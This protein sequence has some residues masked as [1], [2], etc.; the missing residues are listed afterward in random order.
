MEVLTRA[1][2]IVEEKDL[3][4]NGIVLPVSSFSHTSDRLQDIGASGRRLEL[5]CLT[6]GAHAAAL[7][8]GVSTKG[9][10]AGEGAVATARHWAAK[11]A[12]VC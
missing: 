8:R 3:E 9:G 12:A 2:V 7:C 6:P 11:F 5:Q 4:R 1:A 10:G